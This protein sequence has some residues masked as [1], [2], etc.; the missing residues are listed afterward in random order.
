MSTAPATRLE[1][2]SD[3]LERERPLAALEAAMDTVRGTSRGRVVLVA[4]EAGAGKTAL[5]RRFTDAYRQSARVLWGACDA[6]FTPRALGPL[7]D[8]AE[9]TGGDL[10]RVT[11]GGADPHEVAVALLR[12]LTRSAPTV[13]VLEDL[14]WADEAT[15][16]V[17][18]LL[19]RKVDSAPALVVATYRDD[20][21][22]L[23]HPLR[24][25]LGELAT[26]QGMARCELPRLSLDAVAAARRAARHRRGRALP[27]DGGQ[28]VLP[29]RGAGGGRTATS[30]RPSATRSWPARLA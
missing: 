13:L 27:P 14:H 21:L 16:D 25:V 3:L 6:L 1:Q 18:R 17:V 26:G 4:G 23:R 8:V 30:R 2:T 22:A 7:L 9:H 28:P 10:A 29:L 24:V 11:A 5:A 20:E 12:E 15:L 19:A